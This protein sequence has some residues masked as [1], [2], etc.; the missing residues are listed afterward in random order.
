[1]DNFLRCS[2]WK[3]FSHSFWTNVANANR[4]QYGMTCQQKRT[5]RMRLAN[6]SDDSKYLEFSLQVYAKHTH[7][8]HIPRNG[9]NNEARHCA[10]MKQHINRPSPHSVTPQAAIYLHLT[11]SSN[12][13]L[14]PLS[15]TK[16]RL[17]E[18]GQFIV[19]N[20][21]ILCAEMRCRY[22]LSRAQ[23]RLFRVHL[24]EHGKYVRHAAISNVFCF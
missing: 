17:P 8:P 10:A 7:T 23:R 19:E 11:G 6:K 3:P 1:M 24:S 13:C 14:T 18:Y 4:V 20:E 12:C 9:I 15:H 22:R 2:R 5:F 21:F 16:C